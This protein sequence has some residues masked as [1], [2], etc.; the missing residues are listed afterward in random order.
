MI[1]DDKSSVTIIPAAPG[2]QV[3]EPV[4]GE[5]GRA[6]EF[7]RQPIIAWRIETYRN[8]REKLASIVEPV[9]VDEN[10]SPDIIQEPG[11]LI[12]FLTEAEFESE[13]DALAYVQ[14]QRDRSAAWAARRKGGDDA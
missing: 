11:G 4:D 3:L 8:R 6:C 2:W 9:P 1:D 14:A 12:R 13:A 7:Y 5:D 10:E